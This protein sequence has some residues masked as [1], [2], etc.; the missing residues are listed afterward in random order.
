MGVLSIVKP[1]A[2][3]RALLLLFVVGSL[4]YVVVR[5]AGDTND[6]ADDPDELVLAVEGVEPDVV[7]YFFDGDFKCASCE[8]IE[9]YTL[10]AMNTLF[11]DELASGALSYRKH[12][13]DRPR[14][15]HFIDEYRL[16]TKSLVMVE[17]ENGE[18]V[19]WKNLDKIWDLSYDKAK[20]LEYVRAN[21][22]EYLDGAS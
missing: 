7:V 14:H 20:F 15:A 1:K 17:R 16:I 4:A 13:T 5:D 22:Q 6:A 18:Q 11:S 12:N 19:R 10:E 21:T 8:M 2:I 9:A 3:I